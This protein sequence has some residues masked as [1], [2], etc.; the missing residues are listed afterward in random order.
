MLFLNTRDLM[1]HQKHAPSSCAGNKHV[2]VPTA[3]ARPDSANI[4]HSALCEEHF[5]L[6]NHVWHG[7]GTGFTCSIIFRSCKERVWKY[8]P[9][10]VWW[11]SCSQQVK[12]GKGRWGIQRAVETLWYKPMKMEMKEAVIDH[13]KGQVEVL[14]ELFQAPTLSHPK[15]DYWQQNQTSNPGAA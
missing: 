12:N 9:F 7:L 4:P 15:Q 14:W 13:S 1:W 3:T 6:P 8:V 2:L 5:L 10:L 11:F